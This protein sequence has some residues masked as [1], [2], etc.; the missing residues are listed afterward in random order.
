VWLNEEKSIIALKRYER[1]LHGGSIAYNLWIFALFLPICTCLG[2]LQWTMQTGMGLHCGLEY[3][4][5]HNMK[6]S[7]HNMQIGHAF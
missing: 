4:L 1:E 7:Q 3:A 6:I 5:K 2:C